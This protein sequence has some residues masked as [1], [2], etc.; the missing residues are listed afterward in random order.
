MG[1]HFFILILLLTTF[2]LAISASEDE[3]FVDEYYCRNHAEYKICRR[4]LDLNK[5]C[6]V[7]GK[8]CFCDNIAIN[9]GT[10]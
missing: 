1:H 2:S 3:T 4:C 9:N 6:D 5:N 8:G 7:E 10:G